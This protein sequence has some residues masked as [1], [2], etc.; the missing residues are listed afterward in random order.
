MEAMGDDAAREE[1]HETRVHVE[2]VAEGLHERLDH[3]QNLVEGKLDK[4]PFHVP[5]A[6]G[7]LGADGAALPLHHIFG[8]T[9]NMLLG[10]RLGGCNLLIPN[11][12]DIPALLKD[13]AAH[14]FHSFPAG[15]A[16]FAAVAGHPD[17]G[18]V[19]CG[20]ARTRPSAAR[21]RSWRAPRR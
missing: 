5:F 13:L 16:L 4:Q 6:L 10:M 12:H 14:R 17:A 7:L 9:S 1:G 11:A 21:A 8:F 20:R 19:V 3:L 15:G 2:H 18:R